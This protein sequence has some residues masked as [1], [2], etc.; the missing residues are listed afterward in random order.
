[1]WGQPPKK[2][3]AHYTTGDGTQKTS[4]LLLSGAPVPMLNHDTDPAASLL[5]SFGM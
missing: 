5:V 4:L 2:L 1:M 3:T